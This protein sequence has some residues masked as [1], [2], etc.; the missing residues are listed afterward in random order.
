MQRIR[1]VPLSKLVATPET[2]DAARRC[3][4]ALK[5]KPVCGPLLLHCLLYRI[6]FGRNAATPLGH[7]LPIVPLSLRGSDCV[8]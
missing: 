2:A 3:P 1:A 7:P 4:P 5:G 8:R 6:L